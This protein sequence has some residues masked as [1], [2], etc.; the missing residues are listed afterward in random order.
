MYSQIFPFFVIDTTLFIPMVRN[1]RAS[2]LN[3]E[4]TTLAMRIS[5]VIERKCGASTTSISKTYKINKKTVQKW[6]KMY[7]GKINVFR[8]F[9]KYEQGVGER[10]VTYWILSL[11][12]RYL[13]FL[14]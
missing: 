10:G 1:H 9:K 8:V 5:F 3:S 2:Y 7:D 11:S 4:R 13:L 14:Q 12:L 6:V